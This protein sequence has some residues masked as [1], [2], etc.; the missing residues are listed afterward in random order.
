MATDFVS[1]AEQFGRLSRQFGTQAGAMRTLP[2]NFGRRRSH[3]VCVRRNSEPCQLRSR[4]RQHN[5]GR[6]RL[7]SGRLRNNS[8]GC[9]ENSGRR[10]GRCERCRNIP[11]VD[12]A[13]PCACS[14]IPCAVSPERDIGGRIPVVGGTILLAV[15]PACRLGRQK[16]ASYAM[17]RPENVTSTVAWSGCVLELL[18]WRRL[19]TT[20]DTGVCSRMDKAQ[21]E[22]E[23]PH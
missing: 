8:E 13:I 11:V 12:G 18:Q 21:K 19:R 1:S 6:W 14:D 10:R 5:S 4:H 16:R 20:G 3:S 23:N 15:R 22:I 9:R 7:I 2:D 17:S